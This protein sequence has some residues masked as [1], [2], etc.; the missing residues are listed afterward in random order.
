MRILI[1]EDS[2]L[3]MKMYGMVFPPREHVLDHAANGREALRRLA[4]STQAYDVILL[5]LRMPDMNGA[6]FIAEVRKQGG[7]PSRIPIVLTTAEPED[8]PLL[9]QAQSMGVAAIV[10]KP[11]KPQGL[12]DA[13]L[14]AI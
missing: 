13:V 2:P 5:D 3:V 8:S 10:R 14:L 6:E 12:R 7:R 9:Q 11:W 1:V 4:E